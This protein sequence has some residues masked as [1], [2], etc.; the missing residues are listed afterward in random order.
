MN[1]PEILAVL[2]T[3]AGRL[4]DLRIPFL[5]GGSL[6]SSIFGEPRLTRDIDL[7]VEL[8]DDRVAAL[9]GALE[10]DFYVSLEAMREAVAEARSFNAVHLATTIKVDFFVRGPRPFDLEEF[11]RR[12]P[13]EIARGPLLV[14]PVKSIE[15][16]VLRKLRWYRDGGEA[17]S[18]QWRDVIALLALNAPTLDE[19]HLDFWAAEL[20]VSDLLA[21]A[22]REVAG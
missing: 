22:R 18:Q 20:G 5:V 1:E 9:A 21:R 12:R 3:V 16:S 6:A 10:P 11:R 2:R 4:D 17:A 7:V 8:P 14:V 19:P 13:I 15:D